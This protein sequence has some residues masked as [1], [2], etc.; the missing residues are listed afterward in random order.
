[1]E[2]YQALSEGEPLWSILAAAADLLE[3]NPA[4]SGLEAEAVLKAAPGQQQA[5]QLL[6]A[7]HRAQG[8]VARARDALE[9]MAT[10]TPGI[11][12]VHF[13]LGL[14]LAE[15]GENEAAARSLSR[16]IELEPTHP[17][18]W[19]AIGDALIQT[20]DVRGA[21]EA[22]AKQ[23]AST[24]LDLKTLA[25]ISTVEP[26][27]AHE[28]QSVLR[29]YLN[30][31]PTDLMAIRMLGRMY[32]G[33]GQFEAAERM[34]AYALNVDPVFRSARLDHA[35]S[36]RQQM[37]YAEEIHDLDFLLKEDPDNADYRY[38]RATALSAAGRL[39][40]AL[41][42][43]EELIQAEPEHP[44]FRLALA[45]A[46]RTAGQ[47]DAC[48][49]AFQ[50]ALRLEPGLG[51]AW[52][53]L[54]NLKTYRFSQVELETIRAELDRP[55]LTREAREYLEFALGKALEDIGEYEQAFGH[56]VR[57]NMIIRSE[58][59]FD[60]EGIG[61]SV[62]RE[63][64]RFAR[65]FF[66][67]HLNDGCP[68]PAPIFVLGLPRSGSTLVEQILASHSSVEGTGELPCVNA[69]VLRLETK[70]AEQSEKTADDAD[71][72]FHGENLG[73]LGEEYLE[74]C[75]HFRKL[76]TPFFTDK[77]PN[78]FHHLGVIAAILPK[79]RIID[80]RR[81]PLGCCFSNF[82]QIF[83]SRQG[84]SYD[85]VDIGRYYRGYVE[86]MAH[87]DRELPGRVHRVIY[88]DLVTNSEREIR[89]LLE[90][91][92]LPFEEECLGF[93]RTERG[94]KTISSEQVRQ[95]MYTGS[96]DQWRH[97]EPWLGP[98][99]AALGPILDTYPTVPDSV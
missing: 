57:G 55:K 69:I 53:G 91:C 30:T 18:A 75:R 6:V 27:Q 99:K 37:K 71:A 19:R 9:S 63:K 25:Q 16:V 33:V 81:H 61:R 12:S 40:D 56:Y 80:A 92:G 84:A 42:Y 41:K 94:I 34:F 7:A 85:L 87:F 20:G 15:T 10:E 31:C 8:D 68:S 66:S 32:M 21:A 5:L 79:A 95:P 17:Q 59:P 97:F 45:H 73:S 58:N 78:N 82:K 24:N 28:A 47:Q 29:E 62:A 64:S 36:L 86:L 23:F 90:F 52:W 51:A 77:M 43:C 65:E 38:M 88:E 76:A 1:M 72:L 60:A 22:Y 35:A 70:L 96:I 93:H 67:L 44:T 54:A 3:T 98:M 4:K 89:R 50:E 74:R 39:N 83:P 2:Q 48:I 26:D 11:A 46:L 14:L 13:E 49:A